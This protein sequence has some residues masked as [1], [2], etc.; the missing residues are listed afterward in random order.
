M[1]STDNKCQTASERDCVDPN[2][3]LILDNSPYGN[4]HYYAPGAVVHNY[5]GRKN[6]SNPPRS[7]VLENSLPDREPRARNGSEAIAP[8]GGYPL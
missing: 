2:F 4:I 3:Q 1:S 8:Y 5:F 6:M 7:E